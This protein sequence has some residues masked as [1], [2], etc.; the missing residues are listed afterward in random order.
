MIKLIETMHLNNNYK[1]F[2]NVQI[3]NLKD[4]YGK[5]YDDTTKQ[6]IT[7]IKSE[8]IDEIITIK[9]MN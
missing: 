5:Y 7:K 9:T 8:L 4:K 1:Q 2:Q 3:T 6:F